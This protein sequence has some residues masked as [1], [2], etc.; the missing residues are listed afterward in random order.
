MKKVLSAIL[1]LIILLT[2]CAGCSKP[3][4]DSGRIV[5]T[6][7]VRYFD[8]SM[9]TLEIERFDVSESGLVHLYLKDGAEMYFGVNNVIIVK[10]TEEQYYH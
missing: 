3:A 5:R 10:E 8:G 7:K 4:T 9:E 6:A 2:I 1:V